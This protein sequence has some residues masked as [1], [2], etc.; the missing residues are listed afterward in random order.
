MINLLSYDRK[1][2]SKFENENWYCPACASKLA[3]KIG[4]KVRSHFSHR[5]NSLC[6]SYSEGETEEHL[7]G[8][9]L[10]VKW[11]EEAGLDY[12]LEAYL[13]ELSQRPDLLLGD[14]VVIEF[15]CS[16]LPL[17]R[18]LERTTNY[19][20]HGYQVIWIMG[21]KLW[22]RSKLTLLQR[23]VTNFCHKLGFFLWQLDSFTEQL[24]CLYHLEEMIIKKNIFYSKKCLT[25]DSQ[26]LKKMLNPEMLIQISESRIYRLPKLIAKCRYQI[27]YGLL[28]CEKNLLKIQ[29]KLYVE[30]SQLRTLSDDFLAPVTTTLLAKDSV[31]LW[32]VYVWQ[33]CQK[34]EG[35]PLWRVIDYFNSLLIVKNCS[36]QVLP[37]IDAKFAIE[38]FIKE[39]LDYF[40]KKRRIKLVDEKVYLLKQTTLK[41]EAPV[42]QGMIEDT[43]S[44]S[45]QISTIPIDDVVS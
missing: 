38:M 41:S 31:I 6:L 14:K 13:P 24:V 37:L 9:S 32:R 1:T 12:K 34:S 11:C 2:I 26:S 40:I 8:K 45:Y 30:G 15:Q 7:R 3:L 5:R 35:Q 19:L 33:S 43:N 44:Q 36:Y 23:G 27:D 4:T 18:F 21:K 20:K 28:R 10:L 29:E 42:I 16:T 17:A 25:K 39:T 22:V